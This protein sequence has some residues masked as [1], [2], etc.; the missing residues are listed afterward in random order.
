MTAL[1]EKIKKIARVSALAGALTGC[2][3]ETCLVTPLTTYSN[4]RQ[5]VDR[6]SRITIC[7]M[8]DRERWSRGAH[9]LYSDSITDYF[10]D[11]RIVVYKE[12]QIWEYTP[13]G[14]LMSD[15]L[16]NRYRMEMIR[17]Q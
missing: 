7:Q 5:T 17:E 9:F 3:E 16:G 2:V 1:T 13:S 4:C 14:I 12:N 8:D 15:E 11:G 6:W 10:K